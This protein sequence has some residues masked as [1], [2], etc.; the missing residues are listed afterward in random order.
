[1]GFRFQRRVKLFRLLSQS[2]EV[3]CLDVSQAR[4]ADFEPRGTATVGAHGTGLSYRATLQ[5]KGVKLE[6]KQRRQ[7]AMRRGSIRA[8]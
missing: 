7:N 6:K 8:A 3:R 4:P 2:L 5:A 1:M